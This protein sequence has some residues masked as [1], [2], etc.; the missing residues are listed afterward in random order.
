MKIVYSQSYYI[1]VVPTLY[2]GTKESF[3]SNQVCNGRSQTWQP[4][5]LCEWCV[6]TRHRQCLWTNYRSAWYLLHVWYLSLPACGHRQ[7]NGVFSFHCAYLCR[8]WRICC[9]MSYVSLFIGVDFW[10]CR[11]YSLLYKANITLF[12]CVFLC[13]CL[14]QNSIF[15]VLFFS[16]QCFV[17]CSFSFSWASAAVF[18]NK[19]RY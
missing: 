10:T 9:C 4:L 5:V 16:S 15:Y 7:I 17:L 6:Q 18:S 3:I 1:H 2:K 8:H 13:V 14:K 11:F 19:L 12:A